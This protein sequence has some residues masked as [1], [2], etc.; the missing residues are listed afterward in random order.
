MAGWSDDGP[1]SQGW[2][3][4]EGST[5]GFTFGA[6]PN[7]TTHTP[8]LRAEPLLV[9]WR[10]DGTEAC[11]WPI[12]IDDPDYN[13]WTQAVAFDGQGGLWA[14]VEFRGNLTVL[15][16]TPQATTLADQ[17]AYGF[18]TALLHFQLEA[19]STEP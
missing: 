2:F 4:G 12:A 6:T 7:T 11:Y 17:T 16:D 8:S 18:D 5:Y 14:T 13:T 9:T 10:P 19:T 1:L 15:P 3:V